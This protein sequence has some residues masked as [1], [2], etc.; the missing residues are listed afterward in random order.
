MP[1]SELT[2][3]G[4]CTLGNAQ[5]GWPAIVLAVPAAV[6]VV[7]TAAVIEVCSVDCE[8]VVGVELSFECVV[9]GPGV[10]SAALQDEHPERVS[11]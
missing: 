8:L 6:D 2:G 11:S 5:V 10:R 7:E 1:W 3:V 4:G 9:R